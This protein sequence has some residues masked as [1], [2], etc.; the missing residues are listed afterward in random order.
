MWYHFVRGWGSGEGAQKGKVCPEIIQSRA[1]VMGIVSV[2]PKH[3][4]LIAHMYM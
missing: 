3:F 1:K 4:D 2:L